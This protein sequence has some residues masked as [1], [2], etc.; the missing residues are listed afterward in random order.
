M[1]TFNKLGI[2]GRLGNQLFQYSLI[3]SVSKKLNLS[4]GVPYKNKSKN[5]YSNFCLDEGFCI[6]ALDSS[7]HLSKNTFIQK[8]WSF[9]FDDT[10]FKV[11]DDTDFEGF[12]QSEKYFKEFEK[13]IRKEF[14]FKDEIVLAV[15]EEIKAIAE[16][17]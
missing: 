6:N 8:K 15:K 9:H 3:F 11:R 5:E 12:F 16:D 17:V 2:H 7:S 10:V 1:I 13:E 4:F 14:I